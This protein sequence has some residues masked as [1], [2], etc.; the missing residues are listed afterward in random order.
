MYPTKNGLAKETKRFFEKELRFKWQKTSS[1]DLMYALP[2]YRVTNANT[3]F[4]T[5]CAVFASPVFADAP[6]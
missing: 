5:R 6:S 2:T 1:N 3:G 4:G